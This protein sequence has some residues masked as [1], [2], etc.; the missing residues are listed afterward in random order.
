MRDAA[1]EAVEFQRAFHDQE[2]EDAQAIIR[3]AGGEILELTPAAREEFVAA[4]APLYEEAQTRYPQE[5]LNM[6]GL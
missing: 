3:E 1:R 5:L 4:V 2:E 6:V